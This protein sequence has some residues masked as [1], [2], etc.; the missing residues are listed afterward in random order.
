MDDEEEAG[1]SSLLENV[2]IFLYLVGV[3]G[4]G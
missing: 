1:R 4:I 2:L 3:H